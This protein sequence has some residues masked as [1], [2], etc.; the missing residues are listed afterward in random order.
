MP[1]YFQLNPA[2]YVGIIALSCLLAFTSSNAEE[3]RIRHNGLTLNANLEMADG[4]DFS[5]GMVL[6]VH[7][8]WAHN[9][10]EIIETSQQALL[11]NGRSS[12]AITV[13]LGID[14]RHGFLD[15][16]IE[17]RHIQD[18]V[19][20]EIQ[21]WIDWLKSKGVNSVVMM[22]HSRGANHVMVY[23][24]ESKEPMISHLLFLAPGTVGTFRDLFKRRYGEHIHDVMLRVNKMID[25]GKGDEL[26]RNTDFILCPQASVT[27]NTFAS[28]YS[29]AADEKFQNF[30]NY[31]PQ[32]TVPTLIT[33]GTADERQP[34]IEKNVSPYID[35]KLI[36]L[37]VIEGA[38]HFSQDD[39]AEE[40]AN[41]VIHFI[42]SNSS[43]P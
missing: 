3:V 37:S 14:D 8:I 16:N 10:M 23:A 42:D 20:G 7:G 18:D 4:K 31:L 11:D 36:H 41:I 30:V 40:F 24:V 6:I 1:I 9:Q 29:P 26:M 25:A 34:D 15:C 13:S 5:D 43:Q 19:L 12:L 22:G 33:T 21:A 39:A 35:G 32:L 38:G 17:H 27:A 28:Y 2:K